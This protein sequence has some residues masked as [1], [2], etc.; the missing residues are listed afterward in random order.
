MVDDTIALPRDS[1][2]IQA[3]SGA[4]GEDAP[5]KPWRLQVQIDQMKEGERS[6]LSLFECDLIA[7]GV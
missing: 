3:D 7:K 4:H 5:V 2:R 6:D 1:A